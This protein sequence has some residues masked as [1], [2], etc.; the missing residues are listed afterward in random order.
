MLKFWHCFLGGLCSLGLVCLAQAAE[1]YVSPDGSGT[2]PYETWAKAARDIQTAVDHAQAGDTIWI[3]NGV[4]KLGSTI[5]VDKNINLYGNPGDPVVIDGQESVRCLTMTAAA[6][7]CSN[8]SS[9][10]ELRNNC[11]YPAFSANYSRA[12]DNITDEPH[13]VD[14]EG[15]DFRL[16]GSSPCIN[17][18]L[19]EEWMGSALD[20]GGGCR[21]DRFSRLVDIG[22]YEYVPVGALF[23]LR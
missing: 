23:R 11:S 14:L 5:S 9:A 22:C 8:F 21:Q 6:D 15:A 3:F 10:T 20:L 1:L 2:A 17:Q 4:H 16:R 18:G 19:N 7:N 13:F 12:S